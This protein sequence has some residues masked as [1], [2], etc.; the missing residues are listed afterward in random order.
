MPPLYL[1]YNATSPLRAEAFEAMRP[2]LSEEYGNPSS[3]HQGGQR[4]RAAVENARERIAALLHCQAKEIIFTSGGSE[5]I[6][7]ALRGSAAAHFKLQTARTEHPA[8]L[9]C[10]ESIAGAHLEYLEVDHQ[11]QLRAHPPKGGM[12]SLMHANNET[13]VLHPVEDLARL[14]HEHGALFHCDAVQSFGKLPIDLSVFG[15][16][17]LSASAHKFGG[18]KGVGF[19]FARAAAKLSPQ[20]LGGEQEGGHRGGT[21]NVAGIVGM[22]KAAELA[23][24]GMQGE[25]GRLG[26]LMDRLEAELLRRVPGLKVNAG[27]APRIHNTLS[28]ILPGIESDLMIMRLDQEGILVSAGSACAAGAV[29]PSHVLRA[30]GVPENEAK[31]ALR[32]SLGMG[33]LDGDV[34][35]AASAIERAVAQF[36][37]AGI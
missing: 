17:L 11:G 34:D 3:T 26:A 8:T 23:C 20:I 27:S 28:L 19:L 25:A 10:A 16:D 4:A 33:T 29:E 12:V 1:D 30:M 37:K 21:E 6:N 7:L 9:R 24:A 15:A 2:W 5:S 32:L 22:A 14:A 35:R 31:C 18:P 13:G 36:K